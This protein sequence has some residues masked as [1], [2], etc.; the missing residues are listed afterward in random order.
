M[1][2]F[3]SLLLGFPRDVLHFWEHGSQGRRVGGR[4]V[5]GDR[6][7]GHLGVLESGAKESRS[8][9]GVAVLA[10]QHLDDLSGFIDGPVHVPPVPGHFDIRLILSAKSGSGSESGKLRATCSLLCNSI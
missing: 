9:F 2:A 4:F 10:K 5:G 3:D 7:R 8:G 6:V 1:I